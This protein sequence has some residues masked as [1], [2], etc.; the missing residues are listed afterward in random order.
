MRDYDEIQQALDAASAR[1]QAV[2]EEVF[3]KL[4]RVFEEAERVALR[5]FAA[6]PGLA[7]ALADEGAQEAR[8]AIE[9]EGAG[10]IETT[11]GL[12]LLAVVGGRLD[13]AEMAA[14]RAYEQLGPLRQ[15]VERMLT[16]GALL[17]AQVA[18][19]Q[20]DPALGGVDARIEVDWDGVNERALAWARTYSYRLVK[21]L[22]DTTRGILR[23]EIAA[24][25]ER[26]D[27]LDALTETLAPHFGPARASL[28]AAT[29]VTRAFAEGNRLGWRQGR[30]SRWRWEAAADER[31]CG[32]C[33]EKAGRVFGVDDQFPPAHPGC[34]CWGVPVAGEVNG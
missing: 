31:V 2:A 32:V 22:D 8:A 6:L 4:A 25:I 3:G 14:G 17:G 26:G 27:P 9:D 28:I 24:W 23:R 12:M 16:Q 20:V 30:V 21:D 1:T 10:E 13:D 33:G 29:E 7:K 19:L 18:R 34:R 11:L 15:A 5:V